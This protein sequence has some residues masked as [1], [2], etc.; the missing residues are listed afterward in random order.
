MITTKIYEAANPSTLIAE[1]PWATGKQ[2]LH[3][4][5]ETGSGQVVVH[6]RDDTYLAN[7][8]LLEYGNIVRF[9]LDG[10]DRFAFVIETRDFPPVPPDEYLGL[11]WT[12]SG[13]GVLALL[14]D[15]IVMPEGFIEGSLVRQRTFGFTATSYDDSAWVSATQIQQQSSTSGPVT[16]WYANPAGWPDGTAYWIWSRA[17]SAG[18]MPAGTCYFRQTFTV[19]SGIRAA[20]FAT[21]D[22]ALRLW[23]D[24]MLLI[25]NTPD[26]DWRQLFRE[27]VVLAAGT[28]QIAV[29]A[30]NVVP[31]GATYGVGPAGLLVSVYEID[32]GGAPTGSPLVNTDSSWLALDYPASV[33][34]MSIGQI[35]KTLI[36]E[37][38]TRGALNGITLG[39]DETA[40]SNSAYWDEEPD[41]ALDIGTSL[42]DVVQTFVEQYVDVEMTPTLV[43]N[44][45]NKGT[46]GSD[47][48]GS[49]SLLK[50]EDF[51][52]LRGEGHDHLTNA[53]LARDDTGALSTRTD[54]VSLAFAKR[55][56]LYL[57]L[58]LAPSMSRAQD[59]SAQV[60]EEFAEPTIELQ[61][62]VTKGSGVYVSW[63]VG[64]MILM[65]DASGSPVDTNVISIAVEEDDAGNPS[66]SIEATQTD[67]LVTS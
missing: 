4:L 20:V 21:C 54:A 42:L 28:H 24:D 39:F 37:A 5:N 10:T 23:L 48:T 32:T 26:G 2:W 64:D 16:D 12:C 17:L 44:V 52:E 25:D 49:V 35:L 19:A 13:R 9:A 33:P 6:Q 8:D 59:M 31:D 50:G 58:A 7:P 56:E 3:Q 1:V 34:G 47:L 46:L 22:N 66:F 40:D 15:A 43:F 53:I 30:T 63:T 65:P 27:D 38:Q 60:L 11:E 41:L 55:K 36:D 61:G 57:E 14:A 18:V 62:K 51:H 45:Y 67:Q 29:E